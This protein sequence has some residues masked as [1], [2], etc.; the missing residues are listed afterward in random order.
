M[1]PSTRRRFVGE[2]RSDGRDERERRDGPSLA[3]GRGCLAEG[4]PRLPD[5]ARRCDRRRRPRH[6]HGPRVHGRGDEAR[7]RR[8]PARSGADV[9]RRRLHARLDGRRRERTALGHSPAAGRPRHRKRRRVRRC[10]AGARAA[11]GARRRRRARRR[12]GRRQNDGR[13]PLARGACARRVAEERRLDCRSARDGAGS[14]RGRHARDRPAAGAEGTGVVPR[15]AEHRPSGSRRDLDRI[16]PR[17][18]RAVRRG[19]V[20]NELVLQG[21]PAAG[22]IAVGRALVFRDPP[23]PRE[24][25]GGPDEQKRALVALVRVAA[26][27]GYA[28]KRLRARGL[29]DEAEILEACALIAQDPDLREAAVETAATTSAE[30]S[31]TVAAERHAAILDGRSFP[32]GEG[33]VVLIARELGASELTELRLGQSQ[34][35][36]VALAAGAI[37]S[38][39]AIMARALGLPMVVSTGDELLSLAE[40]EVV[41]DGGSGRIVVAPDPATRRSATAAIEHRAGRRTALAQMRALPSV[42]TDGVPVRLLGNASTAGEVASSLEAGAEGVGLLRTELAF[43]QAGRWPT[44]EQHAAALT[45]AL[46]RLEGRLA[47]VRTFDFGSDKTPPF[48][49]GDERRGLDLA[50]AFPDELLAQLRAIVRAGARAQLR[51]LLPLVESGEQVRAARALLALAAAEAPYPALGAMIETPAAARRAAEIAREADFLSIGTN[52]LVQYTLGLDRELPVASTLAAADPEVLRHVAAVA[53]AG[54]RAGLPV[55][56]CGE[57]AGEPPLAAF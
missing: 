8:R 5:A 15:R 20:V 38:H 54:Q 36:G 56:V 13:F 10:P 24:G 6:Q 2:R 40:G 48:L 45:P 17:R 12:R 39:A 43:L 14:R 33:D 9:D 22:G 29:A 25:P 31:V 41:V 47:T 44:E 35:V 3:G 55:E 57:A 50:L 7:G 1:L 51:V 30:A 21:L 23:P 46:A 49:A 28:A 18:A 53:A 11:R 34:I 52:D 32:T 4:E 19:R 27:L 42:T 16:D 37:T 26:E